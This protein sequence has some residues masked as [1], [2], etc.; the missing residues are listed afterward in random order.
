MKATVTLRNF[1]K[2]QGAKRYFP[3]RQNHQKRQTARLNVGPDPSFLHKGSKNDT[4]NYVVMGALNASGTIKGKPESSQYTLLSVFIL[5][6]E[7]ADKLNVSRS[8]L[9]HLSLSTNVTPHTT[10]AR[11][12]SHMSS[13]WYYQVKSSWI[14]RS[15][16]IPLGCNM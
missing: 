7:P 16:I 15:M 3:D 2:Q 12:V 10:H 13:L 4:R 11:K 14:I 9:H 6:A 5:H 1:D 8:V